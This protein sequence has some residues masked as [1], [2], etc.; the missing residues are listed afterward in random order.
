MAAGSWNIL[1]WEGALR[2]RAT[3]I[4]FA[5]DE[6]VSVE[7]TNGAYRESRGV[8]RAITGDFKGAIDDFKFFIDW[9]SQLRLEGVEKEKGQ[10]YAAQRQRWIE[11]LKMGRN[12]LTPEELKSIEN[13]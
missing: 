9:I 4:A 11:E 12:P 1:C 10:A 7:P 3:A 13:Q 2:G 8:V 5:C 6:A